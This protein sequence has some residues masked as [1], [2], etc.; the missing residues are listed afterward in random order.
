MKQL[1]KDYKDLPLLILTK[2]SLAGLGKKLEPS[3]LI[4]IYKEFYLKYLIFRVKIK[5]K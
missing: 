2:I 3:Q 4:N 1:K 5:K